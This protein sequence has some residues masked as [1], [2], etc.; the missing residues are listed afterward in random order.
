MIRLYL[1]VILIIHFI[2]N[3]YPAENQSVLEGYVYDRFTGQPLPQ[4]NIV[5]NDGELGTAADRAGYYYIELP[6]GSYKVAAR[7]VGY[8]PA[9]AELFLSPGSTH[10]RDFYLVESSIIL[11]GVTVTARAPRIDP[12]PYA[13]TR[14]I[15]L[16]E[17]ERLSGVIPDPQRAV[18]TLTGVASNNE[19]SAEF[20]IRGG[21]PDE[22]LIL[23]DNVPLID[24]YYFT[25]DPRTSISFL[26][27]SLIDRAQLIQGNYAVR[28][29]HGLASV[30]RLS[31]LSFPP[32]EHSVTIDL[33]LMQ[34]SVLVEDGRNMEGISYSAAMRGSTPFHRI[35]FGHPFTDTQ[36]WLY[37][38]QGVVR[39]H[40]QRYGNHRMYMLTGSDT[41][42]GA[43]D[44][45]SDNIFVGTSSQYIVSSKTAARLFTGIQ[46]RDQ[47]IDGSFDRFDT[48]FTS[49]FSRFEIETMRSD[50]MS[51]SGGIV[52]SALPMHHERHTIEPVES[53]NRTLSNTALFVEGLFRFNDDTFLTPSL[54]ADYFSLFNQFVLSGSITGG[55]QVSERWLLRGGVGN[56]VQQPHYRGIARANT[57]AVLDRLSVQRSTNI[58]IGADGDLEDNASVRV[59]LFY[60]LLDNIM[61]Q[62]HGPGYRREY[63]GYNDASGFTRGFDFEFRIEDE[64]VQTWIGITMMQAL[65]TDH[66][67]GRGSYQRTNSQTFTVNTVFEYNIGNGYI[68]N[69]RALYG[70]GFYYGGGDDR[71]KF[72]E[73]RR[74]D[75]RFSKSFTEGLV[76]LDI[77]NIWNLSNVAGGSGGLTPDWEMG[78]PRVFNIGIEVR[79]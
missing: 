9:S 33:S 70:R 79:I 55:F 15:N 75:V 47:H 54:R 21:N 43:Y 39:F 10:R 65:E 48:R 69:L 14:T 16:G 53:I 60:H 42:S 68:G 24:P 62:R 27:A 25:Y 67:L 40:D 73:Y 5:I 51:I 37:D 34:A 49:Y 36:A 44:G 76:Y 74:I 22:N 31:S 59:E 12:E 58:T 20:F 77:M 23:F 13:V 45:G 28:Y 56:Y 50:I 64:R 7:F 11:E 2:L 17:I 1:P 3:L 26:N 63:S 57:L 4:A 18:Q 8:E 71:D 46:Y 41:Y 6:H 30:L 61:V 32:D 78:L 38:V 52:F 19:L 29:G 35:G 72:P 66:R